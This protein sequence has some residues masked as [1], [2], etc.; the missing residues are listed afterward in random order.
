MPVSMRSR[1][2]MPLLAKHEPDERRSRVDRS[3]SEAFSRRYERAPDGCWHWLGAKSA[4]GYGILP[5]GRRLG[6]TERTAHR[7]S[8]LLLRGVIPSGMKVLHRCDV[9][10][11]V[12]PEHLFIGTQADNVR[13]MM[14][15]GRG[16]HVPM[17]GEEN[18]MSVL[19]EASV[20]A[21]RAEYRRGKISQKALSSRYKVSVMTINRAVRRQTW[22]HT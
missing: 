8:W 5:S 16:R 9:R 4:L 17:F 10:R 6:T 15:K 14:E 7:I 13:D 11:C 18:P 2:D 3:L 1:P 22:S 19:T 20:I 12:N 21:I